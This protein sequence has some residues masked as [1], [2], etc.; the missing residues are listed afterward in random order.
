MGCRSRRI[1]SFPKGPGEIALVLC[2]AALFGM[3]SARLSA[4]DWPTSPVLDEVVAQ[5]VDEGVTP[6]A[7]LV[8]GHRGQIAHR[9]A[10]GSRSLEPAKEP[11]TLDT[12]FDCASLTKVM[13]TAPAVMQL[14]EQG[15]LRLSDR[16]TKHLPAFSSGN[17]EIRIRE[18]L[19]HYSG[20]R[21]DVDL[22]P[23]WSGYETG[24]QK[25]YAEVPVAP[26]GSRFIYSDINYLL[27]AELVRKLTDM[28]IDEYARKHIFGPL[29][30]NE[31][32][33]KP[34]AGLKP[35]I[36]PTEQLPTGEIL[37]GVVHDP[38]TRYM[39]GVA[40]H[41]GVFSTADDLARF[42]RMMLDQGRLGEARILSP[43]SVIK[44]TTPQSP[45]GKAALRGLGWD[46]D[47]RYA[48]VRGDLFPMGSYGHSGFTGTSVWI[49]PATD[50]FVIL[51]TNRVHPTTKTSV[52]SLRS[53]VAS[54]VAAGIDAVDEDRLRREAFQRRSGDPGESGGSKA[55]EVFTGLDVLARD[56]FKPF[57]G[58][59]VGLITNQT[60]I[61]RNGRT[62]IDLLVKA[63]GVRLSAVFSP[64]HGIDGVL[65]QAKIPDAEGSHGAPIY[66]LYQPGRRR[67]TAAMLDDVDV[68]VF[69]IQD[70][71]ARFYTY[72]TTMA[73]AME[74][75]AEH[76]VPF[77]VL[78]RP[79]PITGAVVEGPVLDEELRS[80]IGY[81][82]MPIRHGMTV[83]ELARMF[84][85]ERAIGARL[86]AIEMEQWSRD[87][88]FDETGLPWVNP[89]PNIRTLDQALL[90]PGVAMLEGLR[91]Y[92]VGR[93]TDTPF[94]FVGADWIDGRLLA[95]R[96]NRRQPDGVGFYAVERT[97]RSS[98]FAGVP[99]SGVQIAIVDREAVRATRLG[100]EIANSLRELY[101]DQVMLSEADRWIG[102]RSTRE[103]LANNQSTDAIY[104]RW[105][106]ATQTF[107]RQR[108]RYLLY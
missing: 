81:F 2:A 9:K 93:G 101:P 87:Q 12:I 40:G 84:N 64:E 100:L 103:D 94:E 85:Q 69:D 98:K 11:M 88:W 42:A 99:I 6:G 106:R 76:G 21:P 92:S 17:S 63:E 46:I 55:T 36:A 33:F 8:V 28:P 73:Y 67:P 70:V 38:T 32:S 105:Q 52:V 75:A 19:T 44:M 53:H 71:G 58:K 7:V 3:A 83:G 5:A 4:Q 35:R 14:V 45:P 27:L 104:Q 39:G 96:L 47:S 16:L 34:A 66:S 82:A 57:A 43:L 13:A 41:A 24:I 25:A 56:G 51:L 26:V 77:Y 79:N 108:Q 102:D 97:P 95:E 50:T 15:K 22:E 1:A 20:L 80:F 86:E 90:Y 91:D 29:E 10:Y 48:S 23:E 74:A 68:L 65:D 61:D 62:N 60:G 37:R 30:M 49:D 18:L 78:D 89:S 59:R 72:I 54:A 107:L 31:T